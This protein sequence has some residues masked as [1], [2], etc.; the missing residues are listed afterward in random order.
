MSNNFQEKFK[1]QIKVIGKS[2][3]AGTMA[4]DAVQPIDMN[5]NMNN[6]NMNAMG[7]YPYYQQQQPMNMNMNYQQHM[8]P[9]QNAWV[10]V[11]EHDNQVK[12]TSKNNLPTGSSHQTSSINNNLVSNGEMIMKGNNNNNNMNMNN[13]HNRYQYNMIVPNQINPMQMMNMPNQPNQMYQQQQQHMPMQ[14]MPNQLNYAQHQQQQQLTPLTKANKH[15]PSNPKENIHKYIEYKPYTLKDYKELTR[16]AIVMGP[17]GA[18]TG[19]KE[20]EEKKAKMKR[21]ESYSNRINQTHKGIT[22]LKKDSPQEE[23]EKILKK[24]KEASNRYK[25][26]EYGKLIRPFKSSVNPRIASTNDVGNGSNSRHNSNKDYFFEDLG[27]INEKEEMK[28][29][30]Q[31]NTPHIN[32]NKMNNPNYINQDD[33]FIP[34]SNANKSDNVVNNDYINDHYELALMQQQQQQQQQ[35]VQLSDGNQ[36]ANYEQCGDV[37]N[38]NMNMNNNDYNNQYIYNNQESNFG[39]N[40]EQQQLEELMK[41]NEL[42]QGKINE[43]KNSLI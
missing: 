18:N 11:Y 21:M 33:N 14:P 15:I 10:N 27:V 3:I 17:L 19:T 40:N 29:K 31:I 25:T 23:I 28:F 35:Q 13:Y 4:N 12:T 34:I 9:Q 36:I 32:V 37:G 6:M 39:S 5:M 2:G 26:Y 1:G 30:E 8:Y 38:F 7:M 24:K 16:T 42:Y 41:Q 43:I 22:R 20:W